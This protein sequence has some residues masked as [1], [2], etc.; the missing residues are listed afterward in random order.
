MSDDQAVEARERRRAKIL[1]SKDARMA[2]ITGVHRGE[3]SSSSDSFKVDE[4]VLQELIAESK[5]HAVQLAKEDYSRT[6][7]ENECEPDEILNEEQIKQR[8]E[9]KIKSQL[10]RLHEI[11]VVSK[12]EQL[13]SNLVVLISAIASAFFLLNRLDKNLKFC[14]NPDGIIFTRIQECRDG[15]IPTFIQIVPTAFVM[16]LLPI[17]S[18]LFKGRKSLISILC[19]A[20]CRSILFLVVFLLTIRICL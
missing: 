6:H 19:S 9:E 15:I 17:I 2:R 13:I 5:K 11:G 16:A 3:S 4:V 10:N 14:F 12:F 7:K 8:Q 1:A 20:L 18:D